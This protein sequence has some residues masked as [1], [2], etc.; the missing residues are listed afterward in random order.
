MGVGLDGSKS[1]ILHLVNDEDVSNFITEIWE[2]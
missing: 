2:R 1:K